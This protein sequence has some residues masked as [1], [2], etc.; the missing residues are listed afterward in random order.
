[1]R[2]L[3]GAAVAA[4]L[5]TACPTDGPEPIPDVSWEPALI[6]DGEGELDLG[7]VAEGSMAQDATITG[8]NNTD[9]AIVFQVD[10]NLPDGDGWIYTVP[11]DEWNVEPGEQVSFG[12]RFNAT[13]NSPDESTGTATFIWDEELVTYIIRVG[14]DR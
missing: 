10:V 1:M 14:V 13:A 12:P 4:V 2:A 6:D 7:L 5:L 9:E 3:A 8:T 11:P